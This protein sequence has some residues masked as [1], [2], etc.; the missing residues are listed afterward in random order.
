MG[1]KLTLLESLGKHTHLIGTQGSGKTTVALTLAR[2]VLASDP[3]AFV[4]YVDWATGL[5]PEILA[6]HGIAAT[7]ERF[8]LCSPLS[9]QEGIDMALQV[10]DLQY[11]KKP[12][13]QFKTPLLIVFDGLGY[14]YEDAD[15]LKAQWETH[16]PAL[17]RETSAILTLIQAVRGTLSGTPRLPEEP[18]PFTANGFQR[19]YV[20][21]E[22]DNT[23]KD[24]FHLTAGVTIKD[25]VVH[26]QNS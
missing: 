21:C 25:G 11:K 1:G 14:T 3:N 6:H 24:T 13:P 18:N 26:A 15:T 9:Q 23:G 2:E 5:S 12:L 22:R 19:V 17:C 10:L 16:L 8:L 20:E 4:L 7:E